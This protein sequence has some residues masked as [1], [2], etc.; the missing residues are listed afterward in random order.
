MFDLKNVCAAF[1]AHISS[2]ANS[3]QNKPASSSRKFGRRGQKSAPFELCGQKFGQ[4]ATLALSRFSSF[5]C[6]RNRTRNRIPNTT[7]V[8]VPGTPLNLVPARFWY[9]FRFRY[10]NPGNDLLILS[11]TLHNMHIEFLFTSH[12]YPQDICGGEGV[13]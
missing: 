6:T 9:R 7:P 3:W 5:F 8:P 1:P 11:E 2:V 10:R 12:S 13:Q 4:L